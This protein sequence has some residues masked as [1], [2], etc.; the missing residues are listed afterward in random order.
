[1][2]KN[3]KKN[4]PYNKVD[5]VT[6]MKEVLEDSINGRCE[7][8]P[9]F[10][11][12]KG[13]EI[14]D[15]SYEQFYRDTKEVGTAI[16]A[17][18]VGSS[19]IAMTGPNS[20]EWVTVYLM[21][22][23]GDGVFVP[24]DKDLLP[25]EKVHIISESDTEIVFFASAYEEQMRENRDK[26]PNV[27]YFVNLDAKED[28][29]EFLSYK[30]LKERGAKLLDEGNTDY[31]SKS[32][33]DDQLKMI[34]YTSG[35]TGRAKGVML[36]S[37]NTLS[38]I[39]YGL[40]VSNIGKYTMA[41]LPFHHTFGCVVDILVSLRTGACIGINDNLRNI[42]ANLKE[43]APESMMMVPLFL[44]SFYKKIMSG[45]EEKGITKKFNTAIKLSNALLK[46]GIDLR[47]KLFKDIHAVF[48]GRLHTCVVGGAP[49]REELGHFFHSIGIVV[50]VGYGIT[51][52]SP[53][54]SCNREFYYNFSSVGVLLPCLEIKIDNPNEDG[55]G[56][57]CVK[58][59][60]VMMGYYKN[61]EQTAEVLT[62]DGWFSTGDYGK[63]GDGDD[64]LYITG[65]KKNIIVL[66]N[67]KNIYPEEIEDYLMNSE[68]ISEVI[69]SAIKNELGEEVGLQA[70]IYPYEDKVKGLT[71]EQAYEKIKNEVEE[72]NS[73][74]PSHKRVIKITVRQQAFEKTTSGKIRRKYAQNV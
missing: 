69:V 13:T 56:E 44:E 41:V 10:R 60:V 71:E 52:C 9:A 1:M 11:Y 16:T 67:G 37:H 38:A 68:N 48:G 12:R 14:I 61:P 35:T 65:R 24:V 43:F 25:E 51:E 70:E 26:M 54:V 2:Y 28:D 6:S 55:E 27:K 58:G 34:V 5:I 33:S 47:R 17:L 36:S 46:I 57:I 21:A 31:T 30:L 50:N 63:M 8:R 64:R 40:Q 45:I 18:G 66:K 20:Y 15:V 7:G 72:I 59:D 23:C 4:Y 42:P 53:L 29:G 22:L 49:V 32:P 3:R 39:N 74:L 19:K 73:K 62:E